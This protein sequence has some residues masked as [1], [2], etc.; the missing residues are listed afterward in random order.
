MRLRILLILT[1]LTIFISPLTTSANEEGVKNGWFEENGKQYYYQN[2]QLVKGWITLENNWYYFNQTDGTLHTGWL[3]DNGKWYFM[4]NDGVMQR[5]WLNIDRKWYYLE[6]SG[7]MKTGWLFNEGKW[8]F[9]DQDGK[10]HTGWLFSAGKWYYLADSGSMKQGWILDN[11]KWYFLSIHGDMQ[12]GWILQNNHWY[13]LNQLGA[14]QIGW[15][16]IDKWYYFNQNGSWIPST[17]ADQFTSIKDN[18]QLI[19]VTTLGYSTYNAKIRTF[20]KFDNKWYEKLN[21]SGY[22]GKE[23]FAATMKEG[24]KKSPRGKYTIGTAFGRYPN[25]GTKLPYRQITNDDVWVD[26]PASTLYNT[27][28]KDS[29]NLGRWSSA[30]KMNISAYNYGFVINYNTV[31]RIPGAG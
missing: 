18:N 2:N 9:L 25:P 27:W 23:G 16:F 19:L 15:I 17:I 21:I 14:M 28:Q 4:R 26:D 13:Y 11:G 10:M 20:E 30:E 8:Y 29:E 12:K 24:A 6:S 5:G 3:Y 22:I 1:L 7:A 31:E